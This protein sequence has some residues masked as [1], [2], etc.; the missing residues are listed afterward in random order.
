MKDIDSEEI[1]KN[2]DNQLSEN[3]RT[4]AKTL[5]NDI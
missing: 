2:K 4:I 1:V 3:N 5:F